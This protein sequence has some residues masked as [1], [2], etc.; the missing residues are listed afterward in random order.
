M[1]TQK[2]AG[3]PFE[4][5]HSRPGLDEIPFPTDRFQPQFSPSFWLS[6]CLFNK[7]VALACLIVKNLQ[8]SNPVFNTADYYQIKFSLNYVTIPCKMIITICFIIGVL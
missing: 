8:I 2:Q 4:T 6:E 5:T 1:H 7:V 3:T